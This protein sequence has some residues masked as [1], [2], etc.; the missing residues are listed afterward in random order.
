[1]SEGRL[2]DLSVVI[3]VYHGADSIASVVDR[4]R[5]TFADQ[6]LQIVLV[7]DGSKDHSEHVCAE[8]VDRFPDQIVFVQLA[9]NF[10]EHNAVICGLNHADGRAV[11]IMDDDAQ[12][13]PEEI[14]RMLQFMQDENLDVVY[15]RYV[16][17]KH[18]GWRQWGSYF[19]DRMA[20]LMLRKPKD[21]YLSSFKVLNAFL[22][23]EIV[24]YRG[25]F[26]YIDG[27][28]CQ[29]TSRMGQVDVK[30]DHRVAGESG[31]TIRKLV[32]LW[33]NM[34]LGF[35]ILPLRLSIL[36]GFFASLVGVIALFAIVID[37]IW[38]N[39][40]VTVGI[41]TVIVCFVLFSGVQLIV[42]G[43]IGEYVGRVFLHT[44]GRPIFVER[45]TKKASTK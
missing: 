9:R 38:I 17:R 14:P 7:N 45:Y 42:L 29:S 32:S 25:P 8:L 43:T 22:V 18:S 6:S 10:G 41:P 27:L 12:N 11:A 36:L 24:K 2:V 40:T 16:D 37:K 1:M 39:P 4:L 3:P 35:S 5:A 31:Y 44:G 15:G 34:F 13:P 19:N 23:A 20:V 21:L 30:H 28:I 33:L 26:P